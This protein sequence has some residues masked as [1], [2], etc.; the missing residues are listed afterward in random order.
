MISLGYSNIN[1]KKGGELL[2][3]KPAR[4]H[5]V[6]KCSY[7]VKNGTQRGWWRWPSQYGTPLGGKS[8]AY[9]CVSP[10]FFLVLP[11]PPLP[12]WGSLDVTS[13]QPVGLAVSALSTP[14]PEYFS[15]LGCWSFSYFDSVPS[16]LL[17]LW[18]YKET[19]VWVF[20]DLEFVPAGGDS[21]W[22]LL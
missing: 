17:H 19:S 9:L 5:I 11:Q 22:L 7:G 15:V 4:A 2:A 18:I 21:V 6:Q 10:C 3:F 12:K 8:W 1:Q 14:V 16:Q 20:L 13:E